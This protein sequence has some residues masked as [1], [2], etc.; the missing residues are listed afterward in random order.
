MRAELAA[1]RR[2]E[3]QLDGRR[4]LHDRH[5]PALRAWQELERLR[6]EAEELV[7]EALAARVGAQAGE[8]LE[9][10]R[11]ELEERGAR[12]RRRAGRARGGAA[13]VGRSASASRC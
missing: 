2:G 10:L 1:A 11:S 7:P 12:A 4:D 6:S 8:R 9:A 5:A 3:A 13:R